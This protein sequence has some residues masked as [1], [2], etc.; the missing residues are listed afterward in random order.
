M[1]RFVDGLVKNRVQTGKTFGFKHN[2]VFTNFVAVFKAGTFTH[3]A[4][5]LYA[6]FHTAQNNTNYLLNYGFSTQSTKLITETTNLNKL[7]MEFV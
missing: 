2:V 3:F 5:V 7:L 4:H 6:K 1:L